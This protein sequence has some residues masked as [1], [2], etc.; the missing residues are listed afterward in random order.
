V[1]TMVRLRQVAALLLLLLLLPL[2]SRVCL[3][4]RRCRLPSAVDRVVLALVL[5]QLTV[6]LVCLRLRPN[7]HDTLRV[8]QL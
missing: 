5:L 7:L 1:A 3:G 4:Q 8:R 2:P 6:C